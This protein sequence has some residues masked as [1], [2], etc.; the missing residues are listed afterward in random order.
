VLS[1]AIIRRPSS[2]IRPSAFT[3]FF[4][5]S[6]VRV[7]PLYLAGVGF[8][9]YESRQ[10]LHRVRVEQLIHDEARQGVGFTGRARR[11]QAIH[12]PPMVSLPASNIPSISL[13]V[14]LGVAYVDGVLGGLHGGGA[15]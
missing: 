5:I 12:L 2:I 11:V 15:G 13:W 9:A 7:E 10:A 6:G 4:P 8:A 3:M 1:D 14:I